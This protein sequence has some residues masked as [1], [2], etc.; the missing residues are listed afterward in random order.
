M[1][2]TPNLLAPKL[3]ARRT[4]LKLAGASG[5]VALMPG[6]GLAAP[7]GRFD[8]MLVLVELSGGNDGLNT[9][10]PYANDRYAALRP[11]LGIARKDVIQ[12][13]DQVGLNPAMVPLMHGWECGDL[14]IVQGLSYPAPNLSHFRSIEI[15]DSA[16]RSDQVIETGWVARLLAA[17]SRPDGLAADGVVFGRPYIGP[18]LGPGLRIAVMDGTESF[19][20]RG[21]QMAALDAGTGNPALD[22]VLQVQGA[23]RSVAERVGASLAAATGGNDALTKRLAAF[24]KTPI[25]RQMAEVARLLSIDAQVPA[26]KVSHTGFDTHVNQRGAHDRLLGELAAALDAF[27]AFARDAGHWDRVLLATYS[28][29]GR[30]PGENKSAG[31]D[32]GTAAPHFV[33]GGQIRGGLHGAPPDLEAFDKGDLKLGL[34]FRQ[35]YA[36]ISDRWWQAPGRLAELGGFEPLPILA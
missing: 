14:A 33:M 9:V 21:I 19:A 17:N 25:G 26:V 28:E 34:D 1:E 20:K 3:L 24:P 13:D 18:L 36:T 30:R 4:I 16:S 5:L 7:A 12:L 2:A 6:F 22:H 32:H 11:T 29:F 8:R 35:L 10:V 31:T 15:W 27:R 23:A